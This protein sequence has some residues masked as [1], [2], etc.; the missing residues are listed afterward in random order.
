MA[1]DKNMVISDKKEVEKIRY[2]IAKEGASKFHVLADFDRTLTKNFVNGREIP[3][4]ISILRNGNYLTE[5][6]AQKAH[7]L[8]NKYHP[9]EINNKI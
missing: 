6:Y 2:R 9:I 8:F 7:A 3:S 5:D 1:E 4:V